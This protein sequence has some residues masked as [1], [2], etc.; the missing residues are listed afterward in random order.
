MPGGR[1]VWGGGGPGG[2]QRVRFRLSM[3]KALGETVVPM[4]PSPAE[5]EAP[6]ELTVQTGAGTTAQD[7]VACQ[8]DP[9]L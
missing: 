6:F 9:R 8:G 2:R 4:G 3:L 7:V 5:A 1:I